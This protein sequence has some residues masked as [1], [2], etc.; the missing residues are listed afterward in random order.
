MFME[1]R[2]TCLIAVLAP[3]ALFFL[4]AYK[5]DMPITA[6]LRSVLKLRLWKKKNNFHVKRTWSGIMCK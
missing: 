3:V 4:A 6:F 2:L 5:V 1:L